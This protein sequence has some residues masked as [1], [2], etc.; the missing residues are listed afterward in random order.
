MKI[1]EDGWSLIFVI[2]VISIV[3]L[4]MLSLHWVHL[5]ISI[6]AIIGVYILISPLLGTQNDREL[7]ELYSEYSAL[8][9]ELRLLKKRKR[10]TQR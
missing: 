3:A 8:Y 10:K 2:I 7:D 4:N 1:G 6:G 9:E 5:W